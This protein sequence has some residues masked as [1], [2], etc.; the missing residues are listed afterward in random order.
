MD[1]VQ[2]RTDE[3][4][5]R[6]ITEPDGVR[7]QLPQA[8]WVERLRRA[9]LNPAPPVQGRDATVRDR[10]EA[11]RRKQLRD[12][13]VERTVLPPDS[14]ELNPRGRIL[15]EFRRRVEWRVYDGVDAKEA[16]VCGYRREVPI[17]CTFIG[18]QTTK[19][20]SLRALER[21]PA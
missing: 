17:V 13:P 3:L 4:C 21:A 2:E 9:Q 6:F 16:T 12:L 8:R 11:R 10:A 18:S 19:T 1:D 20:D 15:K 5:A 14:P 7:G